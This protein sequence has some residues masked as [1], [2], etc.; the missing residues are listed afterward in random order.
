MFILNS[1]W[2]GQMSIIQILTNLLTDV[3][4]MGLFTRKWGRRTSG[5][6]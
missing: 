3:G 4:I 5:Q 2:K 1:V 6:P